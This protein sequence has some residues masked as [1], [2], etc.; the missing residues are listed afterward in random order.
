MMRAQGFGNLSA[1][2]RRRSR[3]DRAR[4]SS[5]GVMQSLTP[6]TS[7]PTSCERSQPQ[8][9]LYRTVLPALS[10]LSKQPPGLH[11]QHRLQRFRD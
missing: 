7:L 11:R 5:C 2:A 3:L 4:R 1:L 10:V 8:N 9:L 6:Q